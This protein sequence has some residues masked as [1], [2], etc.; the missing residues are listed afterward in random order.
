M[1][2]KYRLKLNSV[3][4][5]EE[6][7]QETMDDLYKMLQE[8]QENINKLQ[9]STNLSEE[10]FQVKAAYSKAIHD[11]INDKERLIRLK[12][13]ISKIML[14]VIKAQGNEAAALNNVKKGELKV[15]KVF[16]IKEMTKLADQIQMDYNKETSK[17]QI[18][19][20]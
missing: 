15:D 3:S 5:L 8:I 17:Y 11:F 1:I 16:D 2:K 18:K 9:N 12:T 13:D 7:L 14:E 6:L 19:K 4:S 10:T 20:G